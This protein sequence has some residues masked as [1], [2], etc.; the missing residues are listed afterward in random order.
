[1]IELVIEYLNVV[2]VHITG[3]FTICNLVPAID[4]TQHFKLSIGIKVVKNLG[5]VGGTAAKTY[6]VCGDSCRNGLNIK[7]ANGSYIVGKHVAADSV[8]DY[9]VPI[10][11]LTGD[12]NLV[13]VISE[14]ERGGC[15]VG[16]FSEMETGN[17]YYSAAV[18]SIGAA[19]ENKRKEKQQGGKNK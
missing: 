19:H 15:G 9:T 3:G 17:G 11:F 16:F 2:A 12:D 6:T 13:A 5:F 10:A 7:C 4:D 1:M 14:S 8:E 18:R